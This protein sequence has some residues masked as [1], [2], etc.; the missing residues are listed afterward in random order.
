MAQVCS[1]GFQRSAGVCQECPPGTFKE[2]LGEGR[3][4]PCSAGTYLPFSGAKSSDRCIDC[5]IGTFS[6]DKGAISCQQCASG[7]VSLLGYTKCVQCGPGEQPDPWGAD[8]RTCDSGYFNDGSSQLC[9]KCPTGT[10]SNKKG[11]A[12]VTCRPGTFKDVRHVTSFPKRQ[13]LQCPP[14]TY[15]DKPGTMQCPLCPLGMSSET[16]ATKCT[17]CPK[18]TFRGTPLQRKCVPCKAGT[19]SLGVRPAGCKHPDTGCPPNT[20]EKDGECV[21]CLPGERLNPKSKKCIPCG[22]NEISD[23]GDVTR[24]FKCMDTEEPATPRFVQ[25]KSQ[26]LCAPGYS[27]DELGYCN[28]CLRGTVWNDRPPGALR[29]SLERDFTRD[30]FEHSGCP[31]CP[32]MMFT[33]KMGALECERCPPGMVSGLGDLKCR[34]CPEKTNAIFIRVGG[35]DDEGSHSAL[36]RCIDEKT[37]RPIGAKISKDGSY[38]NFCPVD[39]AKSRF[40]C[41]KCTH[42]QFFEKESN[43]CKTCPPGTGNSRRHLNTTCKKCVGKGPFIA[44]CRCKS[45]QQNIGGKCLKCPKGQS[46]P[47]GAMC[48]AKICPPGWIAK[49]RNGNICRKCNKDSIKSSRFTTV[50]TKCP[51][52]QTAG[53]NLFDERTDRC[54]P[55]VQN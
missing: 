22:G 37:N 54:V 24:C 42:E 38:E 6:S 7:T 43:T 45:G 21:A 34:T 3:C 52:G 46:S 41:V 33:N 11:T 39:T 36:Q 30:L 40:Y 35:E 14:S 18:D 32:G 4:E 9:Q 19:S 27:R 20:F 31:S 1:P 53:R 5:P 23:G 17:P 48:R 26:C 16:G 55:K 25:E 12:C 50:C 51:S 13:C 10:A 15:S 2:E 8:C 29:S 28:P 47:K 49:G 44:G